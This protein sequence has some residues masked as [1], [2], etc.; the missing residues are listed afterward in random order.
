VQEAFP[1]IAGLLLGWF[2][3]PAKPRSQRIIGA[4][5]SVLLG[6]AATVMSGEFRIGWEFLLI[7]IPLVAFC[8]LLGL[9][10]ARL[11]R[12][13]REAAQES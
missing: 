8:A 1:I 2:L 12:R 3:E 6:V 11:V 4:S 9:T 10:A 5:L 7:D 13:R